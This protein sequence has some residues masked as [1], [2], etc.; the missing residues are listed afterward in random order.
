MS[1]TPKSILEWIKLIT[2]IVTIVAACWGTITTSISNK[3]DQAK[4]EVVAEVLEATEAKFVKYTDLTGEAINDESLAIRGHITANRPQV[5]PVET[6]YQVDNSAMEE[7]LTRI[8]T[9]QNL[10]D[11][12]GTTTEAPQEPEQLEPVDPGPPKFKSKNKGT[13]Q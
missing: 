10:V 1:S 7:I 13:R 11:S 8:K 5:Q 2:A 4:A 9:L 6:I 12:L 3:I